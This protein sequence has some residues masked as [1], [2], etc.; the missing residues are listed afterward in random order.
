[1][2]SLTVRDCTP[3]VVCGAVLPAL[4]PNSSAKNFLGSLKPPLKPIQARNAPISSR[5]DAPTNQ[6]QPGR[7]LG[8]GAAA[9]VG[10]AAGR[11]GLG[12]GSGA[13]RAA[14]TGEGA[15][16]IDRRNAWYWFGKR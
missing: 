4:V 13:S 11:V 14:T 10:R 12:A 6:G 8:A 3:A 5:R 1:M 15:A 16:L 7:R 2:S 9:A